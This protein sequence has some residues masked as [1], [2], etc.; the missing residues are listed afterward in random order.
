[1]ILSA[2]VIPAYFV[3]FL[4][5]ILSEHILETES[6]GIFFTALSIINILI[7]PAVV[8]NLFFSKRITIGLSLDGFEGAICE[9]RLFVRYVLSW[10]GIL[11]FATLV[12]MAALGYLL[13]IQSTILVFLI[14]GTAYGIYVAETTRAAFQGLKRFIALGV[15]TLSWTILRFVFGISG[16]LFIGS[17]W[18][19]LLGIL[20]ASMIV[21][22]LC[23]YVLT[24]PFHTKR[25]SANKRDNVVPENIVFFCLTYGLFVFIMYL[26]NIVGYIALDRHYLGVYSAYCI[27]GKG[28]ILLTLPIVQVSFPVIV[29]KNITKNIDSVSIIKSGIVTLMV[30]GITV[31][32]IASFADIICS[33]LLG[34]TDY[35]KNI[36]IAVVISAIPLSLL[37]IL[38]IFQ[39]A[40]NYFKHTLFLFPVVVLQFILVYYFSYNLMY[41]AWSFS[42]SCFFILFYY[43]L[44]IIFG[45]VISNFCLKLVK[46]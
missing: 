30:S 28:V 9:F 19:G 12:I 41:F 45:D 16:L 11:G 22:S 6:F 32:L 1:M 2:L 10:G 17:P 13:G 38:I 31:L 14:C 36:I 40:K 8:L 23:Y 42:I 44:V 25:Y 27:I 18:A 20:V 33:R 39:L 43:L 15:V 37:R 4:F 35:S 5:L 3:N 46:K 26:D 29:E 7:G 24:T 21:F 34:M